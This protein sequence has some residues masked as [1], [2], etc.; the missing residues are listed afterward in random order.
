MASQAS[1]TPTSLMHVDFTHAFESVNNECLLECLKRS[2]I[3]VASPAW[4]EGFL[5]GS[6][7][8]VRFQTCFLELSIVSDGVHQ[9]SKVGP[10]LLIISIEKSSAHCYVA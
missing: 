9:R 4:T 6:C 10:L 2:G 1:R 7:E 5:I 3:G 8:W